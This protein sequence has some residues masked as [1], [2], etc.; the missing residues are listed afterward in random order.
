VRGGDEARAFARSGLDHP[1]RRVRKGLL[2][3]LAAVGETSDLER[4]ATL[5]TDPD[6]EVR[7]SAAGASVEILLRTDEDPGKLLHPGSPFDSED[8]SAWVLDRAKEGL[9]DFFHRANAVR[10]NHD[11]PYRRL[12]RYG[13]VAVAPLTELACDRDRSSRYRAHA[14]LALSRIG[15]PES[16]PVL[17]EVLSTEVPFREL[18]KEGELEAELARPTLLAAAASGMANLGLLDDR[19]FEAALAATNDL[20]DLVRSYANWA[21]TTFTEPISKEARAELV[22]CVSEQILAER[23]DHVISMVAY[24]AQIHGLTETVPDLLRFLDLDPGYVR[25]EVL[26]T[27]LALAPQDELVLA[28]ARRLE[29]VEEVPALAVLAGSHLGHALDREKLTV[30]LLRQLGPGTIEGFLDVDGYGR[31]TAVKAL[32]LLGG[33]RAREAIEDLLSDSDDSVRSLAAAH[34]AVIASAKSIPALRARLGDDSEYVRLFV[35]RTLLI[36]GDNSCLGELVALLEGGN[37]FVMRMADELLRE[38]TGNDVSYAWTMGPEER[39]QGARRWAKVV[40]G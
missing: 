27:L 1:D 15:A 36:L 2:D 11:R 22:A 16:I 20:S 35:C 8:V 29:K 37:A 10:W 4:L 30:D 14:L 31:K 25:Y 28:A 3:V 7:Q 34:L 19:A 26:E 39:R 5:G 33:D 32:A 21:L 17:V 40:G 23:C 9:S 38:H 24:V 6:R 12:T 18:Q 13:L